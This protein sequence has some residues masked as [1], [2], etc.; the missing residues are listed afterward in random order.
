[1]KNKFLLL[2]LVLL[3]A[4]LVVAEPI[5]V[6][7]LMP[8]SGE[9]AS[10]GEAIKNGIELAK[11]E[12]SEEDKKKIEIIIEDDGGNSTTGVSA[13]NRV[14]A[15]NKIDAVMSCFSSVS[16]TIAAIT[17]KKRIPLLALASDPKVIEGRH[18]TF[19]FWVSPDFETAKLIPAAL[20]RGY[21]K[22][23]RITTVHQG[24]FAIR[25]SL[26][27]G[28]NKQI[29]FE[30]DEECSPDSKD[31]R[32]FLTKIKAKKDIDA[33]MPIIF[34]GQ[35]SSFAKQV[36]Q[37]GIHLPLFGWEFFEYRNEV[38]N[39]EGALDDAWYVNA[40]NPT[41][42]FLTHF[43][44]KFPKSSQLGSAHGYDAV[45]VLVQAA[46]VKDKPNGIRDYIATLKDFSG[47]LGTYSSD[48]K[49]LFTMGA[50]VK[51][52]TKDGF[53]KLSE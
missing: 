39:A 21:K 20:R 50:A 49:G 1:M 41:S 37:M 27:R 43:Q 35:L 47:A 18:F 45:K 34:P 12:L 36:R 7:M 11:S 51:K 5:K 2:L 53:I 8:L 32:A 3:N 38:L 33:I 15:T 25:S 23:A 14:L 30:L 13:L 19:N 24:T 17:E 46:S 52:V 6:A 42:E 40:D 10:V 9:S 26:D 22:V 44:E 4:T 48:G 28:N 29:N 31:F 16:N